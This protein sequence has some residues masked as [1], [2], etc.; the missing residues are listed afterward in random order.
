MGYNFPYMPAIWASLIT[1]DKSHFWKA[2]EVTPAIP[3]S[4]A[5]AMF[6]RVHD[7][8]TLEMVDIETRKLIYNELIEKGKQFREGL[9]V[10]GRMANFLDKNPDRIGLAYSILFSLPGVP[11]IYYGDEIGATNNLEYAEMAAKERERVQ[12]EKDKDIDV[13]SFYDSRDINRGPIP[14]SEFYNVLDEKSTY[15]AKIYNTVK[16]MIQERKENIALRRGTFT[17]VISNETSTLAYLR[18]TNDQIILIVNNLDNKESDATIILD[19][20]IMA[21]IQNMDSL[22][23]YLTEKD[24]KF[25]IKG[26]TLNLSMSP[27]EKLW[28]E[29]K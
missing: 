23:D 5:W 17:K 18:S 1:N 26:D 22:Y 19:K 2:S 24:V 9:G 29:L 11:I 15:K 28:L 4:A 7:E 20:E 25:N 14:R 21:K 8:L 13:I 12:K 27:Y 16:K 10:S 3:D 6:L